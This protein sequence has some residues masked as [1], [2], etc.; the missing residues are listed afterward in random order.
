MGAASQGALGA[1]PNMPRSILTLERLCHTSPEG[2]V[3]DLRGRSK[4]SYWSKQEALGSGQS[5][6]R[7]VFRRCGLAGITGL[8]GA[9]LAELVGAVPVRAASSVQQLPATMVLNALPPG[10]QTVRAAIEAGCCLTYTRD[11]DRCGSGGCGSGACCYHVTGSGS[12]SGT[13]EIICV[14]VSCA[15]GNFTTGC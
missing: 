5:S 13:N 12:C 6:R 2:W 11:E 9:G 15:E 3:H 14:D 4:L 1:A 10:E 7:E 8:I